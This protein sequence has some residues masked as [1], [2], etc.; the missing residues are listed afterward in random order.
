MVPIIHCESKYVDGGIHE[1]YQIG[2]KTN[3]NDST[4]QC[5]YMRWLELNSDWDDEP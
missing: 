1:I 2:A 5:H 4:V 3:F